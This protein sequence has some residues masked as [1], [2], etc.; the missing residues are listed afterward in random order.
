[1]PEHV[2]PTDDELKQWADW[3]SDENFI[4]TPSRL[5]LLRLIA[6]VRRL[7]DVEKKTARRCAEM[8]T[9]LAEDYRNVDSTADSVLLI[10]A[11]HIRREFKLDD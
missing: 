4:V 5:N 1:M 6:E 2:P 7:R 11:D 8:V 9:E 3:L 10:G